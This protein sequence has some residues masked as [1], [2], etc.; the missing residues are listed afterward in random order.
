[1]HGGGGFVHRLDLARS[2]GSGG[3]R[4]SRQIQISPP[5]ERDSRTQYIL[6]E[7][8]VEYPWATARSGPANLF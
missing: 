8:S 2:G 4:A 6:A 1:M 7:E 3:S 5:E